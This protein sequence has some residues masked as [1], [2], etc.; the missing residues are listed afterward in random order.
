M[1]E[2]L[3][4]LRSLDRQPLAG[5]ASHPDLLARLQQPHLVV[6]RAGAAPHVDAGPRLHRA[7][8]AG[9][10]PLPRLVAGPVVAARAGERA[11]DVPALARDAVGDVPLAVPRAG[12]G[13]AGQQ[14]LGDPD[15]APVAAAADRRVQRRLPVGVLARRIGAGVDQHRRGVALVRRHPDEELE[16]RQPVAVRRL[17]VGTAR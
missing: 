6:L 17:R 11:V 3:A 12:I 2:R 5:I 13:A 10:D 4:A 8:R 15:L 7:S 16:R 1:D 14:R 9:R